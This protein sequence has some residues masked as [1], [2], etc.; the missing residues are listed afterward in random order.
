VFSANG[1][2]GN[3]ATLTATGTGI[4]TVAGAG[5]TW[6]ISDVLTVADNGTGTLSITAGGTVSSVSG[7]V[8]GGGV[9]AGT[10]TGIVTVDGAG[11]RWTNSD[12]ITVG[13]DGNGTLTISN[14]GT[15]SAASVEVAFG[16]GQGVINIGAAQGAPAVAPGTLAAP[17]VDLGAQGLLVFNHTDLSGLYQFSPDVTGA[18]ALMSVAG[19]TTLM[20]DD[21][22]TGGTTIFAG[23]TLQLGNG[24]TTGSIV[25]DVLDDGALRFNR[26][27]TMTFDGVISGT[28]EVDQVGTGTT[29][30]TGTN[31][32]SGATH[33][34]AGTLQAGAVDTFSPNSAVTVE[35]VGTLD[36]NGFNQTVAGLSNAGLVNMGTG[37]PPHTVLTV[38]GNYVGNGGIIAFNTFLGADDSPSD[39]LV[40]NG[41]TATG[42]S[43]VR[44]T[45]A[46]GL[47]ALT[48]GNG[49]LLVDAINGSTTTT[50]AFTLSGRVAAG[51]FE[52]G[53]FRSGVGADATNDN[54]YLR[55]TEIRPEVFVDNVMPVLA[56]RLGLAMLGTAHDR[57]LGQFCADE[58]EPLKSGLYVKARP[59]DV[60]CNTLLWGRVFG[61]TGAAVSG[62][63]SNS[64]LGSAGSNYTFNYGGLQA[65]A[66]LYRTARDNAGLYAGVATL[67]G[68]VRTTNDGPASR[69]G[70]DAYGFGGYWTHRD[71]GG[72][73]TDLVLQG[74]WYENIRT[75][76]VDNVGF[77][78]H[79]W[80][81]TASAETGYTIA[82]GNGYS[83]IPQAQLIYQRTSLDGGAD[84][85]GLINFAATDEIYARLGGRLAK[86]WQTNDG[87]TVTTWA[88]TNIW[89][90]FGNDAKTTFATLQGTDPTTFAAGLGGTW[91]QVGLG[92]SG[93]LTRNVS[94][95]GVADY[96]IA[97]S[98]PGH[99]I[100]GRTGIKIV[101]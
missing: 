26:S 68:D 29:I 88:E 5:S 50:D 38:N 61:K 64:D 41:G 65:G 4:V 66:D 86:G 90:Q 16:A 8:G 15:V 43:F 27:N 2:I 100:G 55:S 75:S 13:F 87:R 36:L 70:M 47:G 25:G 19:F 37:T 60:Q 62:A 28:G 63:V 96:D 44:V 20:A 98:Q 81:I 7:F 83:A 49:I 48:T 94:V 45:N 84:Q 91:A 18:G 32:Y 97:L 30:W 78:T 40:I 21:T 9:D 56:A 34:L 71:P 31:I 53:L 11:S 72:W 14:S 92:L 42:H 24:G 51:A 95:F 76:S 93:Q 99:S 23:S 74:D 79:G 85:F 73:Y 101:W 17:T 39:V 46:G 59:T 22:Y 52:Y 77:S 3:A 69:I 82:L 33:V 1:T 12:K 57:I 80:G 35:R 54:W 89:H 58:V 6:T 10:G 67:Q